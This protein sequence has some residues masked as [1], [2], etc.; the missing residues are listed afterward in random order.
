MSGHREHVKEFLNVAPSFYAHF[1][2]SHICDSCGVF[3]FLQEKKS[4]RANWE[5]GVGM[6]TGSETGV[7]AVY[8]HS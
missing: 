8:A 7:T 5:P 4:L 3:L 2:V 1:G 6:E